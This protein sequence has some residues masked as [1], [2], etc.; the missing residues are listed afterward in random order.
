VTNV[1]GLEIA[2]HHELLV[3]VVE[4]FA[5]LDEE[6][7]SR[8]DREGTARAVVEQRRPFDVLHRKIG[9]ARRRRAAVNEAGDPRVFQ[10]GE[11]PPLAPEPLLEARIRESR[12]DQLQRH[13]LG[14]ISSLP[15]GEIHHTHTA[16]AENLEQPERTDP[17]G[18]WSH[19]AI[20]EGTQ[21]SGVRVGG[22]QD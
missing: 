19:D 3:G 8:G 18:R 21:E 9:L 5:H 12:P 6:P 1:A 11:D 20:V 14:E 10:P 4:G 7:H 13:P 2:V 22:E 15:L 17:A 16:R